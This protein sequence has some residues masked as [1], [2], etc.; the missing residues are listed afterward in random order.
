MTSAMQYLGVFFGYALPAVRKSVIG[1][2]TERSIVKKDDIV[3]CI[4]EGFM[5]GPDFAQRRLEMLI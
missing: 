1:V 4:G 5:V 2:N 3:K